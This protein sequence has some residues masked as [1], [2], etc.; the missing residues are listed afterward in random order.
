[1]TDETQR[2]AVVN[3]E[4]LKT[5]NLII[6]PGQVILR[7]DSMPKL[8]LENPLKVNGSDDV[9]LWIMMLNKKQTF[10][11]NHDI[12]Y[13]HKE[14][15]N[16]ISL[17]FNHMIS[18]IEELYQKVKGLSILNDID[19]LFFQ[20]TIQY[21]A[22][23]LQR[24]V[25]ILNNFDKIVRNTTEY[26]Q[27]SNINK[28]AIYG[29]GIIGEKYIYELKNRGVSV[30]FGIDINKDAYLDKNIMIYNLQDDLEPVDL[31]IVTANFAYDTILNEIRSKV[32]YP[33]LSIDYF[34][35]GLS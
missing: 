8:W 10:S 5:L 12:L 4:Y 32:S 25:D 28:I 23:K 16:N 22:D 9:M 18:S 11:V 17:D 26:I 21:R 29:M 6:S 14:D 27:N 30:S 20:R 31:I 15:G 1:M 3:E 34:N 33:V 13:T 24:Y 7:R 35:H 2:R 19:F